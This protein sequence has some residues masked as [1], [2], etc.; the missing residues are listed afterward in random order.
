MMAAMEEKKTSK[1]PEFR[2]GDTV[3]VHMKVKEGESERV[4]VF[5]GAVIVRRGR[6]ASE[7]FTVRKISFGVGV[8]RTFLI[9]SPHIEKIE[10]V[11]EGKVR[12]ARLYYLRDLTGKS[13]R[14]DDRQTAAEQASTKAEAHKA[15]TKKAEAPK[16]EAPKAAKKDA[17]AVA[18]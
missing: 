9:S 7:N 18:K 6:G 3:K 8:E 17:P 16:A 5:E 4:Q 14:I 12:R 15:E 10:L 13:A 2:P 11:R 1:A